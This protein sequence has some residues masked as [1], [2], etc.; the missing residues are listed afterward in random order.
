MLNE[1]SELRPEVQ[2]LLGLNAFVSANSSARTAMY[3]NHIGQTPVIKEPT[4]KR[5][6]TGVERR[7]GEQ[8]HCIRMPCD[9]IVLRLVR[10]YQTLQMDRPD[11]PSPI[12]S[13]IYE[14]V[15]TR[16]V[17]VLN[18]TG[19]HS[20]H[21]YFGFDYVYTD[22]AAML[23]PG[24]CIAKDT[25]LAHSPSLTPD[26]DYRF[27][28]EAQV[29]MMSHPDII[30]DGIVAQEEFLPKLASRGYG[31][32]TI[33]IGANGVPIN[34]MGNLSKYKICPDIGERIRPDGL[35]FAVRKI[36]PK[37]YINGLSARSLMTPDLFDRKTYAI[38]NARVVDIIVRRGGRGRS[39]LPVG[40]TTQCE[41]YYRSSCAYYQGILKEHYRVTRDGNGIVS[42][43]F[44]NLVVEAMA[45]IDISKGTAV[46]PT[47]AY[48][49][50]DE[51]QITVVF[52][53]DIIPTIGFKL[54]D[55]HGGKGIIV[56]KKPRADMP[57]DELG[58]IADIIVDGDSTIK[59]MNIGRL[60][61]QYINASG[62][63]TQ[64]LLKDTVRQQGR[65]VAMRHMMR[66]FE[67]VSPPMVE[68]INKSNANI[69]DLLDDV[70]R[71][72]FYTYF[73]TDHPV[74]FH[75]IIAGLRDE[76]PACNAPVTYRGASGN[77]VTTYDPIIIGG[78]YIL[79][80]EKIANTGSAVS[81]A[82]IQNFGTPVKIS[83]AEKYSNP[84]R[85][86]AVRIMGESEC[87]MIAAVCGGD[88]TAEI[89]DQSNNP[90]THR[91]VVEAILRADN[92]TDI[93]HAID[94]RKVPRGNGRV[95][96]MARHYM[97]C[98]GVRFVVNESERGDG[99]D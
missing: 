37:N 40:T 9:A 60:Y 33:S 35:L 43:E 42:P 11:M 22:A 32:R 39:V 44:E 53:Y 20:N 27:G 26:G 98:A 84:G 90:R 59:R 85:E 65:E 78:L 28:I 89:L 50:I 61:E 2:G 92:P 16:E 19:Y 34:L 1:P 99:E 79:L 73:P 97:E 10:K 13:V 31:S 64:L 83:G 25:V 14:N 47:Y 93:D 91:E 94:R 63:A 49:P 74:E 67:I 29:A 6:L 18:L 4:V 15:H 12:T 54:T 7:Y 48:S 69:S 56:S 36:D 51:W 55:L 38:P 5:Q 75:N 68:Y 82:K 52:S 86:Q 58:N 46:T 30:E 62:Y 88:T 76:F 24:A 87:R 23:E 71:H 77:M 21:Q 45:V 70:L 17:G 41:E 72:G 66:W 96:T 8:T 81:S 80:L 57:R 3:G 95:V